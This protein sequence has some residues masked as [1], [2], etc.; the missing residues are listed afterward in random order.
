MVLVKLIKD[1]CRFERQLSGVSLRE[2]FTGWWQGRQKELKMP[3][4]LVNKS[5]DVLLALAALGLGCLSSDECDLSAL[6][7]DKGLYVCYSSLFAHQAYVA[8][9]EVGTE[10]RG[11]AAAVVA[12]TMNDVIERFE[13]VLDINVVKSIGY[14]ICWGWRRAEVHD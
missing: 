2:L 6:S 1:V 8:L 10:A 7:A 12:V 9:D 13:F 14:G 3:R 4:F 5:H 11:A